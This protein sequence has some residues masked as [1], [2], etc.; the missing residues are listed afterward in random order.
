MNQS[1][2]AVGSRRISTSASQQATSC[3]PRLVPLPAIAVTLVLVLILAGCG[4]GSGD[5]PPTSEPTAANEPAATNVPLTTV[6]A[7]PQEFG[8]SLVRTLPAADFD[9]MLGFVAIPGEDDEAVVLT[10]DGQ[11]W[12][13][14][15]DDDEPPALFADLSERVIDNASFEE[16]LLGLAFSPDFETDRRVFV[17]YTVGQPRRGRIAWFGVVDGALDL[18]DEHIVLEIDQPFPNHNGGQIAFGPDGY[19]YIALGD[20]GAAGDPAGNAQDLSTLLGSILRLDVSGEDGYEIP[21][22][23]PFVDTPGARPEIYAYGLRN[24]W[25]FSFDRET[26]DLWTGDVGQN[27]WEETDRVVAGGNYGWDVLEGFECFGAEECETGGFIPPRSVYSHFEGLAVI[28]GFVYR[29]SAMPELDGWYMYGDFS[30]GFIWAV[31]TTDDDSARVILARTEWPISSFGETADGEPLV[32][33]F[34]NAI[35]SLERS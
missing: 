26:G 30:T 14:S 13:A 11:I 25:R 2:V 1:T 24:P 18:S 4:G 29:G 33:T 20:G 17:H 3:S 27:R 15:F 34:A 8:Y 22:D 21:A 23:N 5:S 9:N 32:I 28:G 12:R 7:A 6:P 10:Q 16:G 31:D 35:F 19:L